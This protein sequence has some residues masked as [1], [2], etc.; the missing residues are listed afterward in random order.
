M[1]LW[2]WL[3]AKFNE[4]PRTTSTSPRGSQAERQIFTFTD[5]FALSNFRVFVTR[6]P[7]AFSNAKLTKGR[8]RKCQ[9]NQHKA[10]TDCS[11]DPHKLNL[12]AHST[13]FELSK[14]R[15]SCQTE[16]SWNSGQLGIQSNPIS[17]RQPSP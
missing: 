1:S 6:F 9:V 8:K 14:I 15:S 10:T 17:P 16:L 11:T 12:S 2:N 4:N 7:L 13:D 5:F 3:R